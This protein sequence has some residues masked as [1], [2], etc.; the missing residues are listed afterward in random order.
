MGTGRHDMESTICSRRPTETRSI[1]ATGF[2]L[3]RLWTRSPLFEKFCH[4]MQGNQCKHR[5][6]T[7][8]QSRSVELGQ[9]GLAQVQ[10]VE[11]HPHNSFILLDTTRAVPPSRQTFGD[12][13]GREGILSVCEGKAVSVVHLALTSDFEELG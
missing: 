2:L 7:W 8:V 13:R 10:V 3:A 4:E 12:E 11:P 1:L 9:D 5:L 6:G